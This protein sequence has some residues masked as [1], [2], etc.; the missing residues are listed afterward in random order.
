MSDKIPTPED[1]SKGF[2][3]IVSMLSGSSSLPS[4]FPPMSPFGY[5]HVGNIDMDSDGW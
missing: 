1:I 3:M 4:I 5:I 2:T